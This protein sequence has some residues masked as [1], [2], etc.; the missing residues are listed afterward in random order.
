MLRPIREHENP[1]NGAGTILIKI[2]KL[3]DPDQTHKVFPS[4]LTYLFAR[5]SASPGNDRFFNSGHEAMNRVA[6]LP[7]CIDTLFRT[8]E[9]PVKSLF[10][11][12][13][14]RN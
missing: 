6:I 3:I 1:W 10:L 13:C 9:N 14:T 4:A 8:S 12:L 11:I 7:H 5:L 2:K